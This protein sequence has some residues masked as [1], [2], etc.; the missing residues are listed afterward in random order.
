MVRSIFFLFFIIP[1]TIFSQ[2]Y[3]DKAQQAFDASEYFNAAQLLKS[4]YSRL[5]DEPKLKAKIAFETGYCYRRISQPDF[6]EL[7]LS[8]AIELQYDNPI[9]Y[10]YCAD[11]QLMNEKY[12]EA[13]EN[14]NKYK[15][16][17]PSDPRT[18]KALRSCKIAIKWT[19]NPTKYNVTNLTYLNS[20]Y[21][22]YCPMTGNDDGSIL[23]FSSS[24]TGASGD[25]IHGGTGQSFA[26]IF[27][28]SKDSKGA[29]SQPY[30][31]EKPLNTEIEEGAACFNSDY[32]AMVLTRCDYSENKASTCKI[33]VSYYLG[34]SWSKPEV[35]KINLEK[36]DTCQIAHPSLSA[37]GL[38]MYFTSDLA[39]GFGG[40]DIWYITR[41]TRDD[42]WSA[43]INAG[44]VVNSNGNEMF[45]YY[46]SDSTL[47]F[48]SDGHH[49]MGGL[50]LFRV[51]KDVKGKETLVNL[52]YPMNSPADDFGICFEKN[53]EKGYFSSNRKA[54]IGRDDLFA[55]VLPP[56]KFS[57]TG[58]VINQANDEI[59]ADAKVRLIGNDGTSI[60]TTSDAK[61]N[62]KFTLKPSTNYI[63]MGVKKGFLNGKGKI[64]T[65][66]LEDDKQFIVDVPMTAVDIPV[67]IPNI[68]YDIG[69]WELRPE[70]IVALEKLVE[71]LNDNPEITI[72]LSSHT[73]YRP[74]A[75]SN[76]VLSQRRAQ[77][78]VDFLIIKGI[79]PKRLIAKGYGASL[80]KIVDKKYAYQFNFLREGQ[81]LDR[82]LIESLPPNQ[83]ETA[84]QINRRT[85]LRV[86]STN[87]EN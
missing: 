70:S 47:F 55:F 3:V 32:S 49:G 87:F 82:A 11:A 24:R 86:L 42:E 38:R 50:D 77:S 78:V 85:E 81:K 39:G 21:S 31:L 52:M 29:W 80:P 25:L 35:L 67:E 9:V 57:V 2:K 28:S 72:E 61:G 54:S 19:Q 40:Y 7:W 15:A 56:L 17:N 16:L 44:S 58:R 5:S 65:D 60:E 22:D 10:L 34:D 18:E 43:P 83:R 48:S 37:D 45:P 36:N 71:I 68:M 8:K 75:I 27:S 4:A 53:E 69:K 66:G 74:G 6:A 59:I 51:N 26:D 33:L 46:R 62:Y 63:I 30:Q 12:E 73:D 13:I 23:Y 84:H 20:E 1:L 64:T 79:D 14:Y 76:E 41:P